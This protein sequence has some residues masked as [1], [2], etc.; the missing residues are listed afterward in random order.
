[1]LFTTWQFAGFLVTVLI[2]FYLLPLGWRRY[3][4]LAASLL[5]YMAWRAPYV[6]LI[7][8]LIVIDYTAARVIGRQSGH[9]RKTALLVSLCW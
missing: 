1:M 5:F 9:R 6:V 7:L 4:L 8:G 3:L 2:L